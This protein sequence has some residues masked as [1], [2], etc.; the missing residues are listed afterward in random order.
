MR[1]HRT[2]RQVP[3][4]KSQTLS[5]KQKNQRQN[6]FALPMLIIGPSQTPQRHDQFHLER[7]IQGKEKHLVQRNASFERQEGV[8]RWW[9]NLP[10]MAD[11]K[12]K[13]QPLQLHRLILVLIALLLYYFI[14]ALYSFCQ[15]YKQSLLLSKSINIIRPDF[16]DVFE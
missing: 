16:I 2:L 6:P 7:V 9:G 15:K 12:G 13:F 10:R 4:L 5:Q 3:K 14:K 8:P 1:T 11:N